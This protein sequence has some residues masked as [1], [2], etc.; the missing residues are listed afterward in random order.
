M[1]VRD[2]DN[3]QSVLF[4]IWLPAVLAFLVGGATLMW[5]RQH[6]TG[7]ASEAVDRWHHAYALFLPI[8]LAV[9]APL[10]LRDLARRGISLRA[11]ILGKNRI[12]SDLAL[13]ALAGFVGL[14][15][16][17]VYVKVTGLSLGAPR[18]SPPLWL[19][20][21][22]LVILAPLV[23]EIPFRLYPRLLLG[24]HL[25]PVG[26]WLVGTVAFALFDWQNLGASF[27]AGSVWYLLYARRGSLLVPIT[28]HAVANALAIALG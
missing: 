17:V 15:V 23:K 26:A 28:A 27:V 22:G 3:V 10:Y 4:F 2:R 25:G 13:G 5:L 20:I 6:A 19:R 16:A 18:S 11:Q 21:V 24:P 8:L 1:K 9:L 14:V 7:D 12:A